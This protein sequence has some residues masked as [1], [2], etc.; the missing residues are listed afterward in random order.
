ME[1]SFRAWMC[2]SRLEIIPCSR[3]GHVFRR[4]RPYGGNFGEDTVSKNSARVAEV[5]LDEFKDKFYAINPNAR[6]I[7]Y[8]DIS[9]RIELRHQLKCKSFKWY[10]DNVYKDMESG[11]SGG[12]QSAK[13]IPW[14]KRP[15]NYIKT[16]LLRLSNTLLCVETEGDVV[17]KNAGLVGYT[18]ILNK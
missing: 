8:G 17:Q 11:K 7:D 15:R 10:L 3:V 4:R 14:D 1:L 6:H 2:G 12:N 9:T 18:Y 13:F 16:F 5:W